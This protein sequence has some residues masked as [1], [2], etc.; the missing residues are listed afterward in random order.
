MT[1]GWETT[2]YN[3]RAQREF[4]SLS[5]CQRPKEAATHPVEWN[6][7]LL[8]DGWRNQC[9]LV[10]EES[11]TA[12]GASRKEAWRRRLSNGVTIRRWQSG[13]A[14][15]DTTVSL[16]ISNI[17]LEDFE[18]L[19]SRIC[20]NILPIFLPKKFPHIWIT[21]TF[22]THSKI[23]LWIVVSCKM[24]KQLRWHSGCAAVH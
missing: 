18:I 5:L 20:K 19:W 13:D 11:I 4:L 15:Y 23:E 22:T 7:V 6:A 10:P 2:F 16:F 8:Q 12:L 1:N 21:S 3:F 9:H 17:I 14:M 24:T